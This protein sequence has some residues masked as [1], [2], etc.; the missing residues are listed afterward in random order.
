MKISFPNCLSFVFKFD[1]YKT[2]HCI[3]MYSICYYRF[4]LFN[5]YKK[6]LS[7]SINLYKNAMNGNS[8]RKII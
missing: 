7:F 6:T 8:Y 1:F 2:H 3:Y 4:F 5:I